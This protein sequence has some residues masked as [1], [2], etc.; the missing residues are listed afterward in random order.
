MNKFLQ[1]RADIDEA[2]KYLEDNGLV[3]SGISAKNWEVWQ[4]IPYFRDGNW[5]DL[6]SDGGVLLD[7]LVR[8]NITGF[9]VGVD[10]AYPL[11]QMESNYAKGFDRIKGDLMD[12]GLPTGLFDYATSLSVIEHEVDFSKFAKEVSRLLKSGGH[13]FVSFDYWQP[14]PLYEKRKLYKLDWNI[15]DKQDVLNLMYALEESGMRI[16]GHPDWALKDA[17]I[18]DKYCSP[19]QGVEYTFGI[20]HFKKI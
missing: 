13:L 4:V 19:V 16:V 14:K 2:T 5:I 1:S 9:K 3:Q 8:K 20:F 15:L 10:L 6:G 7:N 12:T 17:V 18:N 11:T